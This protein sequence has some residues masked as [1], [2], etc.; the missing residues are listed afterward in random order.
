M[1]LDVFPSEAATFAYAGR[2]RPKHMLAFRTE[3]SQARDCI[4]YG[5]GLTR[6][7]WIGQYPHKRVL[8]QRTS[9]PSM[10]AV[11]REPRVRRLMMH[12]RRIEQRNQY[13]HIKKCD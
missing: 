13:V 12:V 8:G 7:R 2:V 9:R 10:L 11:E 1:A 5:C 4:L 6:I 3:T